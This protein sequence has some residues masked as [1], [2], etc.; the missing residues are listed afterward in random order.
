MPACTA[1]SPERSAPQL[2]IA[3]LGGLHTL[4]ERLCDKSIIIFHPA[5][6]E[7]YNS[8]MRDTPTKTRAWQYFRKYNALPKTYPAVHYC[9]RYCFVK[10]AC[11]ELV[12]Q[13]TDYSI[14]FNDY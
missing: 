6:K 3:A 13:V 1:S 8:L 4:A 5:I 14:I 10:T 2:L 12:S 11:P 9:C 7:L